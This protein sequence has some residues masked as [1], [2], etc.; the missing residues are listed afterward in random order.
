MKR[1]LRI[2]KVKKRKRNTQPPASPE[3]LELLEQLCQAVRK[4]GVE[5]RLEA[6][7]FKGGICKIKGEK[8]VLFINKKLSIDRQLSTALDALRTLD[9]QQIY[10]PPAVRE[11]LL[12]SGMGD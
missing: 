10:L 2:R 5:V 8:D 12:P 6:G 3:E 11:L 9:H 1:S 4:L 7:N